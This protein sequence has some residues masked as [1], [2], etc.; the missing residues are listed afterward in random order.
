MIAMDLMIL[1]YFLIS[2]P[3]TNVCHTVFV[4]GLY[5]YISVSLSNC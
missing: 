3:K 1:H 4:L 2:K 5:I